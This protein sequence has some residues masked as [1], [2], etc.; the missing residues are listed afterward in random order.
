MTANH[1]LDMMIDGSRCPFW[2]EARDARCGSRELIDG[3]W[4]KRHTT[5]MTRRLAKLAAREEAARAEQ[6]ARA[7]VMLPKWRDR[8]AA[9]RHRIDQLDPPP[10]TTDMAA[11]GGVGST[12]ATRYQ[13]RFHRNLP[14]LAELWG[15]LEAL[16]RDIAHAEALIGRPA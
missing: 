6:R 2:V 11:F 4:C 8:A 15:E 13:E 14:R 10:P 7:A 1:A 16:N 12:T 5:V 9:L 3:R